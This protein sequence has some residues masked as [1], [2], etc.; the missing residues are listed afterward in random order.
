MDN[1][2][3]HYEDRILELEKNF[4]QCKYLLDKEYLADIFDDDYFEMGKSGKRYTKQDVIAALSSTDED[5][6]IE[7]M[8][9]NAIR[10]ILT[11]SWCIT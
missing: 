1:S 9:L 3:T 7:I 11:F 8:I 4:F 6:S 2:K 10:L 5:R